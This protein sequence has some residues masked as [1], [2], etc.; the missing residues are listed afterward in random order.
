MLNDNKLDIWNIYRTNRKSKISKGILDLP[1]ESLSLPFIG[2]EIDLVN[3]E[4]RGMLYTFL[5]KAAE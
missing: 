1:W 3:T 4:D 5:L 2:L